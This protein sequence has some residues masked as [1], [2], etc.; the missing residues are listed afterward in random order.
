METGPGIAWPFESE[1]SRE[2]WEQYEL[3]KREDEALGLDPDT[4]HRRRLRDLE[5]LGL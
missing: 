2:A 3:L 5:E 4:Y 1:P